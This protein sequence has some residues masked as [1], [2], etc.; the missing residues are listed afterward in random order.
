MATCTTALL[1]SRNAHIGASI[2]YS[3]SLCLSIAI[4]YFPKQ[5]IK[6][7]LPDAIST[8]C[9]MVL[10]KAEKTKGKQY[11]TTDSGVKLLVFTR[12]YRFS[13]HL[14]ILV[15]IRHYEKT[16]SNPHLFICSFYFVLFFCIPN[17]L[18]KTRVLL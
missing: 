15:R 2:L 5:L 18:Y 16:N 6:A 7:P 10:Q 4:H 17:D 14:S 11:N 1:S 3:F 8:C 12:F 9:T 13:N